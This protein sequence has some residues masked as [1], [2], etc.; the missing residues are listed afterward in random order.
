MLI[1]RYR[2]CASWAGG[3]GIRIVEG[4]SALP[5]SGARAG[6]VIR[7]TATAAKGTGVLPL[8]WSLNGHDGVRWRPSA[9]WAVVTG[10]ASRGLTAHSRKNGSCAALLAARQAS[11]FWLQA[12]ASV[13]RARPFLRLPA[14]TD[15]HPPTAR[16]TPCASHYSTVHIPWYRHHG[17]KAVPAAAA[18]SVDRVATTNLQ[19]TYCLYV[20]CGRE[21][22]S[23]RRCS[24]PRPCTASRCLFPG[25]QV[26]N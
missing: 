16:P 26:P 17:R 25:S 3:Q 18:G 1:Q 23:Y 20:Y 6:V 8:V 15:A 9:D 14:R 10:G 7:R 12:S 24:D 13:P 22:S 5:Y 21:G 11:G 2:G 19:S 4:I